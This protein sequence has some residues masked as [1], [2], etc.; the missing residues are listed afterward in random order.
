MEV[1]DEIDVQ[2]LDEELY[3]SIAPPWPTAK[4][5]VSVP[6]ES[7]TAVTAFQLYDELGA[8]EVR[9]RFALTDCAGLAESVTVTAK[10]YV[11]PVDGTVPDRL[12][13]LLKESQL[14]NP[15]PDQEY[16]AVPP[17]AVS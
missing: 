12:P 15:L 11:A 13:P 2:L 4:A 16:G 17:L 8:A 7:S 6:L 14:G 10:V 1:P 5:S 9:L 3:L